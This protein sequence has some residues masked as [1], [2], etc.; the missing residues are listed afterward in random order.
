MTLGV[1]SPQAVPSTRRAATLLTWNGRLK[2]T[3]S[4]RERGEGHVRPPL[5]ANAPANSVPPMPTSSINAACAHGSENHGF[6]DAVA[7]RLIRTVECETVSCFTAS[8]CRP[9]TVSLAIFLHPTAS[10]GDGGKAHSHRK[11]VADDVPVSPARLDRRAR[12][13]ASVSCGVGHRGSPPASI[14]R[15]RC[16]TWLA[17]VI[18]SAGSI[19]AIPRR[20]LP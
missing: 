10:V 19:L 15:P 6:R 3:I 18:N 11:R 2:V 17:G 7:E 9:A 12:D 8:Y 20:R 14:A 16:N 13:L 4:R 1:F 5:A